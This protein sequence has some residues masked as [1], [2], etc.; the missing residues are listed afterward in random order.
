[1]TRAVDATAVVPEFLAVRGRLG[2]TAFEAANRCGAMPV[3]QANDYAI[4]QIAQA[5][6]SLAAK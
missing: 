3:H 1:L 2:E 4:A 5:L 6:A